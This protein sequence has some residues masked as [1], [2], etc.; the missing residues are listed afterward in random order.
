MTAEIKYDMNFFFPI[1]VWFSG[2]LVLASLLQHKIR[3]SGYCCS[4]SRSGLALLY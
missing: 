2:V 3:L 1:S 4:V